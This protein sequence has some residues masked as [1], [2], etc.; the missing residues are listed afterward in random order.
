MSDARMTTLR[1]AFDVFRLLT[2]RPDGVAFNQ[3]RRDLDDVAPATLSRLLQTLS[4]DGLLKRE[5]TGAYH[6][7]PAFLDL[8]RRSLGLRSRLEMIQEEVARL[9]TRTRESAVFFE[10]NGPDQMVLAA[11]SE[12]PDSY[13]YMEIGG[14]FG[15]LDR[16]PFG[17]VCLDPVD[18]EKV[19]CEKRLLRY[20]VLRVCTPVLVAG[21]VCGSLGITAI[22]RPFSRDQLKTF[23]DEVREAGR[24]LS[25]QLPS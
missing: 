5:E 11:K 18:A 21:Q 13:S 22:S 8:A 16:D 12:C 25:Q 1:R 10:L 20:E 15:P 6:L 14:T 24:R 4:E 23:Q 19:C 7:G 2:G 9:A 17:L 3:L